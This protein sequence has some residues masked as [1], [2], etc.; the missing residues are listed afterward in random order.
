MA[1]IVAARRSK[2][3]SA[4]NE[5][6]EEARE[7]RKR[8]RK[9][10]E[11]ALQKEADEAKEALEIAKK[12]EADAKKEE[13]E[14]IEA[15]AKAL[16]EE[17]EAEEART[18]L[19]K[20]EEDVL[21][22]EAEVLTLEKRLA[23]GEDVG[24]ELEKRRV[25]LQQEKK[26]VEEASAKLEKEFAEAREAKETAAT[27]KAEALDARAKA[28]EKA[29][30]AFKELREAE[31][32]AFSRG[33]QNWVAHRAEAHEPLIEEDLLYRVIFFPAKSK[34][35]KDREAQL[36][37]TA[38]RKIDNLINTIH[39]QWCASLAT[40][41]A[42]SACHESEIERPL[43]RKTRAHHSAYLRGL[44]VCVCAVALCYVGAQ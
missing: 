16:Q 19:K 34:L 1:S 32:M 37:K 3:P 43:A 15:E 25:E 39:R 17:Q 18:A 21:R 38:K 33:Q 9:D 29:Q 2:G 28:V 12:A 6:R 8:E 27:E 14:A 24:P 13:Q 26:D 20:E 5:T 30:I 23:E 40:A 7:R 10:V 42:C 44:C 35:E 4:D 41:A 22:V 11:L 31:D 36:T